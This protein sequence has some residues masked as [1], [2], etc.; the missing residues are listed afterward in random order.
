MTTNSN[1]TNIFSDQLFRSEI[2][3]GSTDFLMWVT[4]GQKQFS[5]PYL[6]CWKRHQIVG[7]IQFMNS[8]DWS[9]YFFPG[10]GWELFSSPEAT[11]IP[12][13]RR[14]VIFKP[15]MT[16]WSFSLLKSLISHLPHSSAFLS[17]IYFYAF[18]FCFTGFCDLRARIIKDNL[19][20]LILAY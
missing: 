20:I 9:S 14:Q 16:A 15:A 18:L 10:F 3:V 12:S 8:M 4:Q 19:P 6:E 13:V 11:H 7:R 1:D 2:W 17:V 5:R